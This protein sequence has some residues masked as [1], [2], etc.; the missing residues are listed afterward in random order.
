MPPRKEETSQPRILYSCYSKMNREGE[1]FIPEHQF[2]CTLAGSLELYSDG[3]TQIYKEGEF[4]FFRKNRLVKFIKHP[5]P[6]GEYKSIAI[7]MDQGTLKEIS[8]E[9]NLHMDQPYTG[10][11]VVPLQQHN[12]LKKFVDSL[13]PYADD[14]SEFSKVIVRLKVKEAVMILL[15]TNPALKDTLFDFNEPGKIDL[16]AYM[17]QHYLFNL[18]LERFAYLTGRSLS[19]FKRD[20]KDIFHS[21]PNRWLQK[22]RL[23]KAYYQIKEKGAKA[24]DVYL[25]VGFEN[26]SHFSSAFKSVYGIAPS[27]LC[28]H[29]M[30]NNGVKSDF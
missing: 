5:P 24:S 22:K 8:A 10:E 28:D 30:I 20:F 1:Q 25:E 9:Y 19:T 11:S 29:G 27:R 13:T 7:R 26:L 23:E 18:H 16:E 21:T 2:G 14:E 6:G 12:L 3:K 15:E 4:R 17:N